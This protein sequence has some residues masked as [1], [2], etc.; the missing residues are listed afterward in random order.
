ML[1]VEHK[2]VWCCIMD[3]SESRSEIHGKF[4]NMVLEKDGEKHLDRSC[5][6]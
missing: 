5:V 2:F 6:K 3:T 1:H 4:W